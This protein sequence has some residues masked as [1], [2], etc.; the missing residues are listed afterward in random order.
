MLGGNNQ[1]TNLNVRCERRDRGEHMEAIRS[2]EKE[3]KRIR[4]V[5][6][7]LRN[8]LKTSSDPGFALKDLCENKPVPEKIAHLAHKWGRTRM[9]ARLMWWNRPRRKLMNISLWDTKGCPSCS[10]KT[11]PGC[12]CEVT[13]G[14]CNCVNPM[15]CDCHT[16]PKCGP[17]RDVETE[18]SGVLHQSV[19]LYPHKNG[20]DRGR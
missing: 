1:G 10:D 9:Q 15:T 7:D 4:K 5:T 11:K 12:I 16:I 8:E 19:G 3:G 2:L 13:L 14:S 18:T 17:N 6:A 20:F